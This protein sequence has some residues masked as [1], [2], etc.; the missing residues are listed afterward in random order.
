MSMLTK[1]NRC[2]SIREVLTS[3]TICDQVLLGE[4]SPDYRLE[5][6]CRQNFLPSWALSN[7][8][9]SKLLLWPWFPWNAFRCFFRLAF[10]PA[11]NMP[12]SQGLL[13]FFLHFIRPRSFLDAHLETWGIGNVGRFR[14]LAS[15][16]DNAYLRFVGIFAFVEHAAH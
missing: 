10:R 13:H 14:K 2:K 7:T 4:P 8:A 3:L 9:L 16:S 15:R 1:M 6:F 5:F 11:G 12:A